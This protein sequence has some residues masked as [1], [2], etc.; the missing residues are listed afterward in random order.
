MS[1]EEGTPFVEPTDHKQTFPCEQCG[2]N[3]AWNPEAESL[4]CTH[5]GHVQSMTGGQGVHKHDFAG[6]IARARRQPAGALVQGGHDVRCDG[7]GA[8]TAVSGQAD[9][10]PFC[11]S[12]VVLEV[13]ELGEMFA[14]EG[15]L[16]FKL[17][18][19]KATDCYTRWISKLWFAPNDLK[20]LAQQHGMD[21][22]YL[23]YWCYDSHT[24]TRYIGQRGEYYYVTQT[25]TDNQ[26]R[27]QTRQ[28]RH[29]RWYGRSGTVQHHF[30]DIL[31][32]ASPTLPAKMIDRLEPWDLKELRSYDAAYLSGF[33]AERYKHSL[34]E[35]FKPAE[36]KMTPKII[37]L[38]NADIGGDTQRILSMHVTHNDVLF[39]HL[40][41]P[42]WIS[43]FRYKGKTYRFIVNARSGEVAGERPWSKAKIILTVLF[44]IAVIA[45]IVILVQ[46][47]QG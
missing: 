10:C 14:P 22:V 24:A 42:L 34:E 39:K 35:S 44:V 11:G 26:G 28:V 15:V 16:P 32:C 23:P 43:S 6:A 37:Q 18:K 8:Q 2:A 21:G 36:A 7:C 20:K 33:V 12:P 46:R 1:G 4:R 45:T 40:L 38:V 13:K 31:V 25:Y 19:R 5:C 9:R 17:D 47:S 29:T 41:L 27:T 30:A 3:L